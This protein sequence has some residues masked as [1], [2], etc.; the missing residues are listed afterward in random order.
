VYQ[1]DEGKEE[2]R[3]NRG[4]RES[5]SLLI[6]EFLRGRISAEQPISFSLESKRLAKKI[7]RD[8]NEE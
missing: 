8:C 4:N 5:S 3:H 2:F 7:A 6:I 1:F